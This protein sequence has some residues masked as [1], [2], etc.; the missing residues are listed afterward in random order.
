M[1]YSCTK[2]AADTLEAIENYLTKI[3]PFLSPISHRPSSNSWKLGNDTYSFEQGRENPDGAITGTVYQLTEWINPATGQVDPN[4]YRCRR[5][6]SVRIEADG[7]VTRFATVK[8]E[9]IA[10]ALR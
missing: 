4:R 9:I 8:K 1:G 2:D 6:G 5:A 7:R 10:A 3:G